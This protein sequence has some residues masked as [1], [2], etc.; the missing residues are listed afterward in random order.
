[1]VKEV[2]KALRKQVAPGTAVIHA[3]WARPATAIPSALLNS[4]W[5]KETVTK[6]HETLHGPI[7]MSFEVQ[8]HALDAIDDQPCLAVEGDLNWE[9]SL[10]DVFPHAR[11]V[12]VIHAL[13]HDAL[14]MNRRDG[15]RG[16]TFRADVR[17]EGAVMV[18]SN[19]YP[20][21]C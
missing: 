9:Q 5:E 21:H 4:P 6:L 3:E 7:K 20:I 12:P 2:L 17:A 11:R 14:Q 10:M 16:W 15:H 8:L 18:A 1:M 13:V 19:I